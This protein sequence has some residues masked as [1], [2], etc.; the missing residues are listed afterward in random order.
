[1][2]TI[3]RL[4]ATTDFN[5]VSIP[6]KNKITEHSVL[7]SNNKEVSW[8]QESY[9]ADNG[10]I[11]GISDNVTRGREYNKNRSINHLKSYIE[12]RVAAIY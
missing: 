6:E 4:L 8:T 7:I 11:N 3:M 1:M 12:A 10:V 2:R 5:T 9:S